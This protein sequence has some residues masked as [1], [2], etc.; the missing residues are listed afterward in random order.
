MWGR[1]QPCAASQVT[2]KQNCTWF[3]LPTVVLMS[4]TVWHGVSV[5]H[6]CREL[7]LTWRHMTKL[8]LI[9]TEAYII[10]SALKKKSNSAFSSV[11]HLT[12]AG[13]KV[14]VWIT[15]QLLWLFQCF[16]PGTWHMP[17]SLSKA[18]SSHF[19]SFSLF[20][21]LSSFTSRLQKAQTGVW[22]ILESLLRKP[23]PSNDG[24]GGGGLFSLHNWG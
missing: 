8:C 17:A 16:F 22:I 12:Y 23:D 3:L 4:D 18:H 5:A 19:S 13:P 1:K 24:G 6:W 7:G 14:G 9:I 21:S 2:S 11:L 10:D 20:N 15:N